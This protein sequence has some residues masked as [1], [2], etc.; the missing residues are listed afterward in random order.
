MIQW[1]NTG[2]RYGS[3]AQF[4]HW[5]IFALIALQFISAQLVDVFPRA[6]A[7]RGMVIG[8]HE[9]LGLAA[10]A[11]VLIRVSWRMVNPALPGHGPVWQQRLARAAHVGLYVLMVAVPVAGYVAGAARGHD[12]ALFGFTLPEL[13]GRDRT[14]A[15]TAIGVHEVLAWTLLALVAMH[16]AAAAWHHFIAGDTTLRRMLPRPT[17]AELG[18]RR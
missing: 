11:L 18:L 1:R 13:I 5:T 10:L 6:S 16:A 15:R 8:V 3:V 14:L 12:L 2:E 17:G 4:L 7:E 9:S